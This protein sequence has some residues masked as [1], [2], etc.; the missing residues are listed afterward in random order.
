MKKSLERNPESIEF[1]KL[2]GELV[3]LWPNANWQGDPLVGRLI[4][5]ATH[6]LGVRFTYGTSNL[7]D[8]VWVPDEGEKISMVFKSGGMRIELA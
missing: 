5:V 6:T 1:D 7:V 2:K 8:G 4:W 3:H